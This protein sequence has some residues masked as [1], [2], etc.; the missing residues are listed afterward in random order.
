MSEQE[1]E[2]ET[3]PDE[4]TPLPQPDPSEAQEDFEEVPNDAA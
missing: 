1:I 3:L 2:H 4:G